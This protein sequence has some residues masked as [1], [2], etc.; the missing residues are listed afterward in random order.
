MDQNP[1]APPTADRCEVIPP[2]E[3]EIVGEM[4]LAEAEA[5]R[6]THL[7]HEA[8]LRAFGSLTLLWVMY[9]ILGPP[10]ILLGLLLFVMAPLTEGSV[11]Q[12]LVL[13]G[14]LFVAGLSFVAIGALGYRAGTGLRR[15]DPQHRWLYSLFGGVWLLSLSVP[16]LLGLWALYL[17]HS[18][19]GKTL[20]SP[21]YQEARRLTPHIKHQ[22]SPASWLAFTLVLLV[23]PLAVYFAAVP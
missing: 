5:L 14:V 1:Y 19:A 13:A 3:P 12:S 21:A 2:P 4:T 9:L 7:T 16:A 20:F 17:I 10:T 11:G 18:P 15:L 23:M 8:R 6:R 22:M